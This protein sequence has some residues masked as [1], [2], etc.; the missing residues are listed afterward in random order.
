MR[1]AFNFIQRTSLRML[2]QTLYVDCAWSFWCPFNLVCYF[3]SI[4]QRIVP[5]KILDVVTVNKNVFAT[6]VWLNK[7][8]SFFGVEPFYF[9]L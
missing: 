3:L 6:V 4:L 2:V 5:T 8:E 7:S 9:T 1:Q